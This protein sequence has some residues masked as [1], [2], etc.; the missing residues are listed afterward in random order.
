[1][2]RNPNMIFDIIKLLV[3]E[4]D[5]FT[6]ADMVNLSMTCKNLHSQL[7]L[8]KTSPRTILEEI[9]IMTDESEQLLINIPVTNYARIY[10]AEVTAC[11]S[12]GDKSGWQASFFVKQKCKDETVDPPNTVVIVD[13]ADITG[14]SNFTR[15]GISLSFCIKPGYDYQLWY[16]VYNEDMDNT[17]PR[18]LCIKVEYIMLQYVQKAQDFLVKSKS[19]RPWDRMLK[20]GTYRFDYEQETLQEI[21]EVHSDTMSTLWE[22]VELLLCDKSAI[23][24][25]PKPIVT[26]FQEFGLSETLLTV[27]MIKLIRNLWFEGQQGGFDYND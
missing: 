1:M 24:K 8:K 12:D 15:Q 3:E 5:Y 21:E 25:L 27:V 20:K 4:D 6:Q 9:E 2:S 22:T 7:T 14:Q 13:R 16:K 19:F 18:L 23:P 10:K 17:P 11:W 26:F